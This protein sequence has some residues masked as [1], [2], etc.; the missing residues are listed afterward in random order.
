M[1]TRQTGARHRK[2]VLPSCFSLM[3]NFYFRSRRWSVYT[4]IPSRRFLIL[5]EAQI[6]LLGAVFPPTA[7]IRKSW[8][9]RAING[10]PVITY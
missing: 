3:R 2:L 6:F 10:K 5:S 4:F 7:K 1:L 8:G 9:G